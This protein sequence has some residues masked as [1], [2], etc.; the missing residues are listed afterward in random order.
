VNAKGE[1]RGLVAF[2]VDSVGT[3]PDGPSGSKLPNLWITT[4]SAASIL[5]Q[6]LSNVTVGLS[7]VPQ[8]PILVR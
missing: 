5:A 3:D 1:R 6:G 8:K 7:V 4:C 2:T